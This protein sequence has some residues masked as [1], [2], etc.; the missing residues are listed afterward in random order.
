MLMYFNKMKD[1]NETPEFMKIADITTLY[2]GKGEKSSMECD[3]GIFVVSVFRS[4]LMKLIYKDIYKTIDDSMS[5]S[6]VG[7]RKG[8]NIRN[9]IWVL[10]SV[11]ADTLSSNKKKSIDVQI[12]DFKQCFDSLWLEECLNDMYTGGLKND[13]FNLVHSVNQNVNIVVKTPVGKTSTESIHN[14]VIQGDVLGPMLCSKQVDNFGKECLEEQKYTFLYR[15]E[16]EIPPLTMVDDVICISECGYKSVMV[17]EFMQCKANTKKL[18]FGPSK[19]KKMHIGKQDMEFKCHALFVEK[20]EEIE[21]VQGNTQNNIIE[22]VCIG[23]E[24]MEKKLEEKYLGDIISTDGKNI[25]NIKARV[26][27]GKGISRKILSILE[28]IPFGRLYYQVAVLLRN[29]L[30]VSSLLCNSEAWFGL[31]DKELNLLESVDIAFLRSI[32]MAPKSTPK[33]MFYLEL[34]ILPLRE[35]IRER[36][37]IFLHYILKQD[38]NSILFKIF[39]VQCK[40]R[41]KKDWVS[42][43]L[44]DL[45]SCKIDVSFEDVQQSTK[46]KWKSL[47]K[48]HIEEKTMRYLIT[49]K[50]GHSKVMKIEHKN[51]M[52]QDYLLPNINKISKEEIQLIFKLRCKVT[53]V[54]MNMK[55]MYNQFQCQICEEEEESQFHI[56]ECNK[57][58]EIR[59]EE[60]MSNKLKYEMIEKGNLKEKLM[61]AKIFYE[62]YK[63]LESYRHKR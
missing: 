26:N 54:K 30:L 38:A 63:I 28:G 57:I 32:L 59:K 43:I 53:N 11:I 61:I 13:Q 10:N 6:Q 22:D 48:Q 42:T 58:W 51:L 2:K 18:Q 60:N 21:M 8:K 50:Q 23:R 5:D 33:E 34:G 35:L 29:S 31:T 47:V 7:S 37:L 20:W 12:Y 16:V 36:R 19:C 15:G 4:I 44:S 46:V 56:Y 55:G 9:H 3:R 41:T 52:M 14:V 1:E 17:N 62:N 27:K 49:L 24:E 25:K 40:T 39:E 45:K